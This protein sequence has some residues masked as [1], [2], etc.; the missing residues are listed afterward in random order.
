MKKG[1]IFIISGPAG[2][3]KDTIIKGILKKYPDFV[4]VKSYTTRPKRK[5]DEAGNR[6]FVGTREFE[7]MIAN[8][9][10]LEWAKVHLWYY[11]RK[12]NDIVR[13]IK[14]GDNVIMDVDVL[15]AVTYEKIMPEVISIFVNYENVGDFTCRLKT[16]RPEITDSELK[17]RRQSMIRELKYQKYYDYTI[18]N[19]EGHPEK[20]VKKVEKIIR[21]VIE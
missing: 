21:S 6:V 7:K 5:S 11:G 17:I 1:K 12:K 8:N 20:A 18:I 10:M 15:G 3:G 19:F 13:H 2:V 14:K 9:E 16:N 4:M